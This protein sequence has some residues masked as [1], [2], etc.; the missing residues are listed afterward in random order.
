MELLSTIWFISYY[1]SQRLSCWD[2]GGELSCL[3]AGMGEG[4]RQVDK[5]CGSDGKAP[6]SPRCCGAASADDLCGKGMEEGK[7][8]NTPAGRDLE[9]I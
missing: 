9:A 5:G 2:F 8:Q 3:P 7:G 6:G 1:Y 4:Y